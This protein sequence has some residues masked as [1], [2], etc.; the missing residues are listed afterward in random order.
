MI[1]SGK[2]APLTVVVKEKNACITVVVRMP[3]L[4]IN[5]ED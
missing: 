1:A 3:P 2:N 4:Q 5:K